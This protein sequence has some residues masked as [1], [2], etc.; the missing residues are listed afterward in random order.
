MFKNLLSAKLEVFFV[1]AKPFRVLLNIKRRRASQQ[2]IASQRTAELI[3]YIRQIMFLGK[4][5]Y[6]RGSQPRSRLHGRSTCEREPCSG[7]T[8]G[9]S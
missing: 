2:A 8:F 4:R 3:S 7:G 5:I 6:N 1:M 9:T